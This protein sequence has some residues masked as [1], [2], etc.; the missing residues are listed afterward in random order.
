MTA[1]LVWLPHPKNKE[2]LQIWHYNPNKLLR[3]RTDIIRM[4]QIDDAVAETFSLNELEYIYG[5]KSS[6]QL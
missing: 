5:S 1:F 4:H 6:N 2:E 3:K